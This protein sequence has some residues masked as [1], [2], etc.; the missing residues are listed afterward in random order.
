MRIKHIL[1][2]FVG[3]L[4]FSACSDIGITDPTA[5]EAAQ[6]EQHSGGSQNDSGGSQND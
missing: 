4:L 6:I 3:L 5:D 1:V 2:I